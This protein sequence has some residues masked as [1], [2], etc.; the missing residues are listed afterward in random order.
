MDF[1]YILYREESLFIC[2]TLYVFDGAGQNPHESIKTR[3]GSLDASLLKANSPGDLRSTRLKSASSWEAF[4][5]CSISFGKGY[6]LEL[7]SV[8]VPLLFVIYVNDILEGIPSE[9]NASLF[10]DD[11]ALWVSYK[12][13]DRCEKICYRM[14][15]KKFKT[16]HLTGKCK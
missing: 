6:V 5:C 8:L 2:L 11:L 14:G 7:G 15:Y 9:V 10:A 13:L 1:W 12:N 3:G 4:P 16:G